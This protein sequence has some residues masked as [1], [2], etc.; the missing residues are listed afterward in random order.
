[1]LNRLILAIQFLT[2]APLK[3]NVVVTPEALA[4]SMAWFP[5]VGAL[6]GAIAALVDWALAGIL[7]VSVRAAIILLVLALTNGGLHLD[8]LADTVD[9]LAG[10]K[11][12][13]DRMRIMRDPATGP[14]GAG[15]LFLI[16]LIQY[17]CLGVIDD[18][19]VRSGVIILFPLTG[20]WAMVVLSSL[21]R[22]ARAEG[23]LG[24]AFSGAN[25]TTLLI[26]T[27]ITAGMITTLLKPLYIAI[28][29]VLCIYVW[30]VS[31]FFKKRLGGVTGDVFGF[32]SETGSTLFLVL[33]LLMTRIKF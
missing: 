8:G 6:Q 25:V 31:I 21:S 13:E 30:L 24:K 20:R 9:G 32:Q 22:Y 14:I 4:G 17:S 3:R 18:P 19:V 28:L 33:F 23:G 2:L 26:S 16:L 1:M 12:P 10:G 7:P 15:F 27:V 11:T 5:V 29:P